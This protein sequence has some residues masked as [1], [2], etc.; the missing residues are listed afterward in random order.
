M[1]SLVLAL[2]LTA[3]PTCDDPRVAG[4][5]DHQRATACALLEKPVG[6]RPLNPDALKS[7]FDREGFEQARQRNSGVL[8]AFLAQARAWL[9]RLFATSGAETY[10]NLTRIGVLALALIVGITIVA[11]VIGRRRVVTPSS[12]PRKT[13]TSL[14]L[15]DPAVHRQRAAALVERDPRSA[16]REGWLAVLSS[17]ER[18]R[19]A[20]PDRVKTNREMVAELPA[21]GAPGDLT[22]RVNA[23]VTWFDRTFYSLEQ[24]APEQARQFLSDIDRVLT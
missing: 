11:R 19:Y 18:H 1:I 22:T 9:E 14:Q 7:I 17:L 16:I 4:L 24:V 10:S 13:A 15:D 20:R 2:S 21:R 6:A 23:L 12:E 3:A 8:A 5:A